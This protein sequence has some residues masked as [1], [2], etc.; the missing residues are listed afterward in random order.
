MQRMDFSALSSMETGIIRQPV[1]GLPRGW[2]REQI[3]R[4]HANAT[5]AYGNGF[6][7]GKLT[8][9]VVYYSPKGVK[10]KSKPELARALGDQYDVTAFDF[11]TGKINPLLM[12]TSAKPGPSAHGGGGSAGRKSSKPVSTSAG[13][14]AA[15]AA[16]NGTAGPGVSRTPE[17]VLVPPIRQTAS[18]FKQPVTVK[19]NIRVRGYT[20][21]KVFFYKIERNVL[22]FPG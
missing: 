19:K 21:R 13:L 20:D 18:I 1:A 16:S 6:A 15:A 14:A 9:D 3:P 7:N 22:V 17:T 11:Q 4:Y 12:R 8:Y 5:S 2:I 10:V